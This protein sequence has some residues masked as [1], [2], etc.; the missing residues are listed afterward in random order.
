MQRDFDE[1]DIKLISLLQDNG[2]IAN[3]ELA[4]RVGLS[5]SG[6]LR[7]VQQLE[8]SKLITGYHAALDPEQ[9][10]LELQAFVRVLLST[11]TREHLDRFRDEITARPEVVAVYSVTGDA[12]YLLHVVTQDLKSYRNLLMDFLLV[13][14]LVANV[15]T[16]IVLAV[17]KQERRLP[18]GHLQ[19]A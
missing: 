8:S 7:R 12:D 1:I 13:S 3:S 14:P 18:L 16:S 19:G 17:D 2:R 11:S 5:P 6:C 15:N 10:G 4:E 9:T